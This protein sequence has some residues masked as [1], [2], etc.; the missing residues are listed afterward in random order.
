MGFILPPNQSILRAVTEYRTDCS[1]G[2]RFTVT[3]G[4]AGGTLRCSCGHIVR[5]PSLHELRAQ[6]GL[7]PYDLSPELVIENLLAAGRLPPT[8]SCTCC[9]R[10]TDE[11]LQ[12][13]TE[14]ER[15]WV[16]WTGGVSWA[17]LL[18]MM[19]LPIWLWERSERKEFGRDKI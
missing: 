12:V 5:V 16:R 14:C 6:I 7:T 10:E 15:S 17:H 1:C 9:G 4:D 8:K 2:K 18:A 19:I 13:V 3:E 11:I